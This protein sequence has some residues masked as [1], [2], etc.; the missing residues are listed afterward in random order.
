MNNSFELVGILGVG[1][2]VVDMAGAVGK[3]LEWLEKKDEKKWYV[4]TPNVEFIVAA[5]KDEEF[6]RILNQADLRIPD[7][8]RLA[9]ANYQIQTKNWLKKII[10]WP[11]FLYPSLIPKPHLPLVGGVYLVEELCRQSAGKGISVGFLGGQNGVAKL[12][13]DCMKSKYPGLKVVLADDGPV[14]DKEGNVLGEYIFPDISVD[15]LFVGFGQVK[16]EKWIDK[17][18]AVLPIKVAMG[19]GGSFDELSGRLPQPPNW[20]WNSGFKWLFRLAVEPTRIK[21][22]GSLVKF[23]FLVPF[24]S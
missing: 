18:L 6:K 11:A 14:V 19:V 16:Q 12:A 17:S 10:F 22:F 9:W 4:V 23:V 15:I 2:D 8:A 24:S 3:I 20:L 21:R 7:S 1:V 13:A 5:Q